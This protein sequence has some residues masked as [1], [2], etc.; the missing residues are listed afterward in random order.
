MAS[1]RVRIEPA[2][3]R[4]CTYIGA[5]LR[6]EDR[7]EVMCQVPEGMY[8]S[9][10]LGSMLEALSPEW[11]RIASV[12]GQPAVL[13]GFQFVTAPVW[14][15]FALGTSRPPRAIPA[16]TRWCWDQEQRLIDAGV[17]RVEARSIEGHVTAHRW[18]ERL[19]C[20]RVCDLPDSGRNG[21]LFHLYAWHL[22]AGRP[23][24]THRYRKS[25]ADSEPPSRGAEL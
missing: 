25:D 6:P 16:I 17:R 23:T 12:D 22:G 20:Q 11:T 10:V 24:E 14:Q 18:L 5:N 21:E 7:R 15:S 9:T 1:S 3:L 8:G 13:F 19:G 4:D 2:N